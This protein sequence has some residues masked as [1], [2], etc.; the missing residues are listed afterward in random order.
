MQ[1]ICFPS[2][3]APILS[4][5]TTVPCA[6]VTGVAGLQ[7]YW[8]IGQWQ[9]YSAWAGA[10]YHELIMRLPSKVD[11]VAAYNHK[12]LLSIV[13]FVEIIVKDSVPKK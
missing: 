11:M 10:R 4:C 8:I 12:S 6:R 9:I 13:V 3:P 1:V 7:S 5:S 2:L